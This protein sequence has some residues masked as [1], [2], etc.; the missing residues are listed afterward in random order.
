MDHLKFRYLRL[1]LH[2]T[3]VAVQPIESLLD[4][5]IPLLSRGGWLRHQ[6]NAAKPPLK[7][8]DGVVL[9]KKINCGLNEPPRP[10]QIR[11]LRDIF[12][13]GAA[14]PPFLRLRAIALAL[15]VPRRGISHSQRLTLNSS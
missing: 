9:V 5:R 12:I 10:R 11:C 3:Q 4:E 8:A 14:T 1:Q 15:R 7:G 6:Q 13:D 2:R